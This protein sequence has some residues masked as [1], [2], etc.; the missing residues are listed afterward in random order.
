MA[1]NKEY[2]GI[3]LEQED[4]YSA[5]STNLE[6]WT[7]HIPF[8]P[9]DKFPSDD[10]KRRADINK[11]MNAL[12]SNKLAEILE[13]YINDFPDLSPY[14]SAR[15]QNIVSSLPIFD[16]LVS[17]WK[18]ILTPCF[19][20]VKING[21]LRKD[22]WKQIYPQIEQ[23][24]KNMFTCCDRAT[25]VYKTSSRK[26]KINVYTDRNIV[27]FRTLDDER[28][29]TITNV[30]K[31]K[32]GQWLECISYLPDG[33]CVRDKFAYQNK[34]IGKQIVSNEPI[35]E[36]RHVIFAKNGSD[37]NDYGYPELVGSIAPALGVIRAFS[38]LAR[39]IEQGREELRVQPRTSIYVDPV[40]GMAVALN[41][42]TVTYDPQNETEKH[43]VSII[44]PEIDFEGLIKALEE[45]IKQVSIYSHL[46]GTI[47]GTERVSGNTSG[48][49]LLADCVPTMLHA[50]GYI[51]RLSEELKDLVV[52]VAKYS[53][54]TIDTED[55]ELIV[56][57]PDTTLITIIYGSAAT[58]E[59]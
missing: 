57:T 17:T 51:T 16:T 15:V 26:T 30:T 36:D 27:L 59:A 11:T 14:Q 19:K 18:S 12:T 8:K 2:Y 46:S 49:Q 41:G 7:D 20:G 28:V 3:K 21:V 37:N 39:N 6:L 45:M 13:S 33:R 32:T 25:I 52:E 53:D 38:V 40:T 4:D 23:I 31:N 5:I 1:S 44:K 34:K 47:L 43:D 29:V 24:I 22:L 55:I 56:T 35:E 50:N 54:E 42:G 58:T 9:G 10:M 48:R